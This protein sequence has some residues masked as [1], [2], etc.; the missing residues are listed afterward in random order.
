MQ[1]LD[2]KSIGLDLPGRYVR[3]LADKPGRL[4]S[5]RGGHDSADPRRRV[6]L[7]ASTIVA[8][9]TSSKLMDRDVSAECRI[10]VLESDRF[11][12]PQVRREGT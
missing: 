11:E 6:D 8:R 12:R 3:K 9:L 10:A 5:K 7:P 1:V 2:A 4:E